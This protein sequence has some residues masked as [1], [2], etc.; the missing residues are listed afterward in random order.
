MSNLSLEFSTDETGKSFLNSQ[1]ASYPF[2]ICGAQ[3]FESDPH[4]MANIY[5][6][7]ASGGIYQ[8]ES[9][10]TNVVANSNSNSHVTTQAST[11]VHSMPEGKSIQ[12]INVEAKNNSYTEYFSDPLILFP[13][14]ELT[15][16]VKLKIDNSSTAIIV[17][18]FIIHQLDDKQSKFRKLNSNFSIYS[19]DNKLLVR[20]I[21]TVTP[22]NLNP[23]NKFNYVGMGT[24]ALVTQKYCTDDLLAILQKDLQE[25]S[26]IYGG[27]SKLPNNSGILIKFLISES[28]LLKESSI[29]YW[30]LIRNN[31]FGVEPITRR[32]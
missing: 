20:D 8:N 7:S 4:G 14:S 23:F 2:H 19:S 10:T 9:L 11:I 21:Y 25:N 26:F 27:A 15:S 28:H 6:Q 31:I 29:Y 18:G 30:K 12:T 16:N 24:I 22:E 1:F 5:I 17:D 3:Y 32:K 13:N